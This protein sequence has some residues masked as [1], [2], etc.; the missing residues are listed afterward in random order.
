[1]HVFLHFGTFGVVVLQLVLASKVGELEEFE[2]PTANSQFANS[3][4]LFS[5]PGFGFACFGFES[6]EQF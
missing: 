5:F 2:N 6:F 3:S 4:L 1:M